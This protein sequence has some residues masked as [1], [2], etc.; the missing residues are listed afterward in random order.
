MRR[1]RARTSL[2]ALLSLQTHAQK[3][4]PLRRRSFAHELLGKHEQQQ[5]SGGFTAWDDERHSLLFEYVVPSRICNADMKMP[6]SAI[7]SLVDETTTWA[8]IGA[9]PLRRPGVSISLEASLVDHDKPARAGDRLIFESRVHKVGRTV[10]FIACDIRTSAGRPVACANHTKYL[11][12]GAAWDFAFGRAFGAT[13]AVL[14]PML[15]TERPAPE[16]DA[17]DTRGFE[18]LLTPSSVELRPLGPEAGA[19]ADDGSAPHETVVAFECL[20]EHLQEVSIVF[21]G[22]HAMMHER[23]ASIA[24]AR[25]AAP[26]GGGGGGGGALR[27]HLASIRVNYMSSASMGD[28]LEVPAHSG[29][30]RAHLPRASLTESKPTSHPQSRR[31][32]GRQRR[33]ARS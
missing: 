24:A 5:P 21:G 16:V 30:A 4:R 31:A 3:L 27:P 29:G 1:R 28:V 14:V 15:S 11:H 9:D 26:G 12:M 13:E 18:R 8:S 25:A 6:L 17:D 2:D 23:A 20:E 22:A 33:A 7:L 32:C 19:A 10:G